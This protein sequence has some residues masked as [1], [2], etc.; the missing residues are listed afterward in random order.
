MGTIKLFFKWLYGI[1]F[2]VAGFVIMFSTSFLGGIL[3]MLGGL[4]LFPPT[5]KII[6]N[7]IGTRLTRPIKYIAVIGSIF[8]GIIFI[9]NTKV[10]KENEQKNK[11]EQAS[12]NLP[13]SVKDSI[14][15]EKAREDSL[16]IIARQKE[17]EDKKTSIVV[18]SM[19]VKKIDGKFKYWFDIRNKGKKP[20]D[21]IVRIWCITDDESSEFD[22]S[23]KTNRPIEPKLGTPQF[24]ELNTGITSF[25]GA[26]GISKFRFE[27]IVN[28]EVVQTGSG[29]ITNNFEN[30]D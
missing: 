10:D 6:E 25:H 15:R 14:A 1:S 5:L 27:V 7:K 16:N 13:Q 11:D 9:A 28:D 19:I 22:E 12:E 21:G 23:F 4:L 29:R 26:N 17:I 24:I 18:T 3:F 2:T 30:L 20:F 8:I